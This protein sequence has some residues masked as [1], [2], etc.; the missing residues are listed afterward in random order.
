MRLDFLRHLY[1]GGEE[2]A[3]VYLD[4]SRA[5]GTAAAEVALRWRA[6]RQS[7]A[8]RGAGEA[9]LEAMADLVMV[10]ANAAPGLAIFPCAGVLRDGQV[11]DLLLADD[12]SSTAVLWIG[13]GPAEL[14]MSQDE[15]RD[16]GVAEPVSDRADA[17]IARAVAGTGAAPHFVPEGEPAPREG[18]GALLRCAAA[19]A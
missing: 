11:S 15:L 12:P 1:D 5:G 19:G 7:L 8:G 14:A 10:P 9:T 17:A 18:I 2:Y 3:S 4:A 13:P 16:R 6:A